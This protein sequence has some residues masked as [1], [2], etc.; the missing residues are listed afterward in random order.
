MMMMMMTMLCTYHAGMMKLAAQ[1]CF[2]AS[3]DV[4]CQSATYLE[5][6]NFVIHIEDLV[7]SVRCAEEVSVC[8][9]VSH[10]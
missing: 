5:I 4:T 8:L 2:D 6:R 1:S 3:T 10:H 7:C 9:V